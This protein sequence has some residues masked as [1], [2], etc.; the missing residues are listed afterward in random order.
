MRVSGESEATVQALQR[1]QSGE[2]QQ[3]RMT[4]SVD[5][6][7]ACLGDQGSVRGQHLGAG[8]V[9]GLSDERFPPAAAAEDAAGV[10]AGQQA[11]ARA[12]NTDLDMLA[13]MNAL[14]RSMDQALSSVR[15]SSRGA[16]LPPRQHDAWRLQVSAATELTAQTHPAQPL[17]Q[18]RHTIEAMHLHQPV[19]QQR[20]TVAHL[21]ASSRPMAAAMAAV[22]RRATAD[23][24]LADLSALGGRGAGTGLSALLEPPTRQPLGGRGAVTAVVG[25]S[26]L[27]SGPPT[28]RPAAAAV[29]SES[30]S[31]SALPV[32]AVGQKA[33]HLGGVR[34]GVACMGS[35]VANMRYEPN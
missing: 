2:R 20:A 30:G 17:Q 12:G 31:S 8:W 25:L 32:R 16:S 5:G 33:H 18:R 15:P 3:Q 34:P 24:S 27:H 9:D 10:M 23:I 4:W 1:R 28:Q 22:Q 19:R 11:A 26:T 7:P 13:A 35:R 21:P 29:P 14:S 6:H